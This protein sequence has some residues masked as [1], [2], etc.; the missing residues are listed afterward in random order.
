MMVDLVDAL[1]RKTG[2]MLIDQCQQ[3]LSGKDFSKL[4]SRQRVERERRL[5]RGIVEAMS[6]FVDFTETNPG[7]TKA[8]CDRPDR[9][10]PRVFL[11]SKSLF[12]CCRNDFSVDDECC[13]RIVSLRDTVLPFVEIRLMGLLEWN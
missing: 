2:Q 1:A 11:S 12:C 5:M 6:E 7:L 13:C 10:I 3:R 8:V 4:S 9:K